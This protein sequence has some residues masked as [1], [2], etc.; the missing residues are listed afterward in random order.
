MNR[1]QPL[2]GFRQL[3]VTSAPV[4]EAPRRRAQDAST[5]DDAD[6]IWLQMSFLQRMTEFGIERYATAA[7]CLFLF[8]G[9]A[10]K[11]AQI[12]VTYP[13]TLM[14]YGTTKSFSGCTL[15]AQIVE[16]VQ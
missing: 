11:S 8:L 9:C 7:I 3:A 15:G 12:N 5:E 2:S 13:C 6:T 1:E 14:W 4:P 10:G 16:Q